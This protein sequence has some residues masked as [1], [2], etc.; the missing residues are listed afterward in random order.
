MSDNIEPGDRE[1]CDT[2]LR[3]NA[4]LDGE[5]TITPRCNA[6]DAD[7]GAGT[8]FENPPEASLL[9]ATDDDFEDLHRFPVL[10]AATQPQFVAFEQ[11][12]AMPNNFF[13]EDQMP[14]PTQPVMTYSNFDHVQ[15]SEANLNL[16]SSFEQH[17]NHE[18][19]TA[20]NSPTP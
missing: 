6:E 9:H 2:I 8:V 4:G 20:V 3:Y 7:V 19:I 1:L 5:L 18:F 14:G 16:L 15:E 11:D 10:S 13:E 12:G 17:D